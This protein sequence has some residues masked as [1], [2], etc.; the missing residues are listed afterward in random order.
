[1]P[2]VPL[3][4]RKMKVHWLTVP[5]LLLLGRRSDAILLG[6]KDR[7]AQFGDVKVIT[8]HAATVSS[9][10]SFGFAAPAASPSVWELATDHDPLN[11]LYSVYKQA[12]LG[13]S[14][15]RCKTSG[16]AFMPTAS[17]EDTHIPFVN[18]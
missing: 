1:M 4:T 15:S 8:E 10:R 9:V 13:S 16:S 18:H 3:I 7:L 2:E 17:A 5:A 12:R 14:S 11:A 6:G